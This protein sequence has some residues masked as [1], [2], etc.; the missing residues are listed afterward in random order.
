MRSP[1][2]DKP[3]MFRNRNGFPHPLTSPCTHVPIQGHRCTGADTDTDTDQHKPTHTKGRLSE[4]LWGHSPL[5]VVHLEA[6]GGQQGVAVGDV[7]GGAP[8]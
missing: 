7:D 5:G 4:T 8:G 3:L 6:G 2:R 1:L